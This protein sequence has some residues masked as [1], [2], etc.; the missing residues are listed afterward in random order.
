[1]TFGPADMGQLA[2]AMRT[3][4]AA[5]VESLSDRQLEQA[6]AP[7]D[8]NELRSWTYLP[9]PR[10]GLRVREL[11]AEQRAVASS[12]LLTCFSPRGATDA[13]LVVRTEAIRSGQPVDTGAPSLLSSYADPQYYLRLLGDPRRP[14][15]PWM[16]RLSGHHLVAQ[17]TVTGDTVSTTP[18]F[19]GTQPARVPHGPFA[20]FRGLPREEDF[21]RQLVTLLGE[22][23]RHQAILSPDAPA[24]ILT[25]HD[26]VATAHSAPHGL[27]H[28]RMDRPQRQL[29]EALIRQYL[30]R[31]P[32]PVGDRA[33]VDLHHAGL[34]N[35]RFAWAGGLLPG[36]GHYYNV[37]GQTLLLEY[38]NTQ[39]DANHIH[40]VWRDLRHDWG[41]DLLRAHYQRHDHAT[42]G[43][44]PAGR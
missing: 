5:V 12:L 13:E 28:D 7:F 27:P 37:S 40:S 18:Q 20:G 8:E 29:F 41:G 33:W 30:D 19:F 26:P 43:G 17:A 16:W 31:A 42:R 11:S 39:E 32:G 35:V 9:G 21:A 24:D 4:A 6:L 44:E 25:R 22:D 3:A 15:G 10:P 34:G 36:Q 38:D 23:Q 2:A 14:D 1:M